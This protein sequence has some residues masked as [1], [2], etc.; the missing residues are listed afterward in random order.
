M[1]KIPSDIEEGP[2]K[3]PVLNEQA[4]SQDID[5]EQ[6]LWRQFAEATTLKAFCQSWLSLQCHMLKGIRSGLVL[7]GTPDQGPF[8]LAA[9]WP[10]PNF[11]VKHLT[12]AAERSLKERRGLLIKTDST[13][14]PENLVIESHHIAYPI[15][16]SGK[17]HGVVVLEVDQ[18]PAHEVQAI[19][20]QLHWG[21]AWLEVILRRGDR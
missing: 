4:D 6:D 13:Q 11:S 7:L 20:R 8:T 18:C 9:V 14:A 15:E 12:G 1:F 16:V 19:M 10:S 17:V 2:R 21:S 5:L 3:N